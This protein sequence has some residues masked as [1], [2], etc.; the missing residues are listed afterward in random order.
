MARQAR[1]T[2]YIDANASGMRRGVEDAERSLKRLHSAGS[3]AMKGLGIAAAATGAVALTGLAA[4]VHTGTQELLEQEKASAQTAAAIKSTGGAANVTKKQIE[5]MASALQTATGAADDQVQ[6]AENLL[7]T[8]TNIRNIGPDKIFNQATRASL[9]LSVAFNKDLAGSAVLVGKALNDPI[10]GVSALT[11]VGVSFTAQQK[12][13]IKTLV[14][15]GKTLEAQKLILAELNR[16]VGGSAKA[17]ANT[18]A[19]QLAKIQRAWED[20]SE[21]L[22]REF[23][24]IITDVAKGVLS[25]MDK[26][27]AVFE[28]VAVAF[29]GLVKFIK[30]I[31]N[32]D[33]KEAW[34]I[35]ADGAGKALKA[36]YTIAKEILLPLAKKLGEKIVEGIEEGIRSG[37]AKLPGGR[38]LNNALGLGTSGGARVPL[39]LQ[40]AG[41]NPGYIPTRGATPGLA[42]GG[43]IPGR[44][45]GRDDVPVRVSRGEVILNPTQQRIV[46]IDRIMA[47]LRATGGVVG[48]GSFASG[49][50]VKPSRSTVLLARDIDRTFRDRD[51]WSSRDF[52]YLSGKRF[53]LNVKRMASITAGLEGYLDRSSRVRDWT[54]GKSRWRDRTMYLVQSFATGGVVGGAWKEAADFARRQVGEPYVWG[55]GHSYGDSRGWD[56]SGFASNVAA[57]VPGYTG[58]IG[59]TMSLYPKSKPARGNEPVVFGFSGMET[60][61]PRKQ[62]MGIRVGGVWY[63]AGSGGVQTGRTSW[64]SGL[65]VPPGLE[66]LSESAAGGDPGPRGAPDQPTP[67]KRLANLL[68]RAG[69]SDVA[70]NVMSGSLIAGVPDLSEGSAP[71]FTP[72]Q[73]R[74]VS[75]A[76]RGARADARRAGKSPEQIAKAGDDAERAAEIKLLNKQLAL[77]REDL[78]I[79]RTLKGNTL[80]DFRRLGRKKVGAGGR[81]AKRKLM[82][83]YRAKLRRITAEMSE[84]REEIEQLKDRLAE[85]GEAIAEEQYEADYERSQEGAQASTSADT[86]TTDISADQ[87]A[88][89]DQ[90]TARAT[91]A[92]RDAAT[93][94]AFIRTL[95]GSGSIDPGTGSVNVTIQTLTPGDPAIQAEVARWIVGAFGGQ[96]SVPASSFS[97]A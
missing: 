12:E 27:K 75:A 3:K 61:D 91:T 95:F 35:A 69:F 92:E 44:F 33:W 42:T 32:G 77:A 28:G 68:G 48:G 43:M 18:T 78:S 47:T 25:N 67:R 7:L 56:C 74:S 41:Q 58:G 23:L 86:T 24:P 20:V 59:T 30:A 15:S 5:E 87:Q 94:S 17:Q 73:D 84:V 9:D 38:F 36:I 11:R 45:D 22:V 40:L 31:A 10:K 26:V 19:G 21:S 76:G 62:H 70:A 1:A 55:A 93:G 6:A 8:F 29:K 64:P 89:L 63:D 37:L 96:G 57:R 34:R 83:Q 50:V 49:G 71:S 14:D 52:T 79:L 82:A 66:G 51:G 65:R 81:A 88:Q 97:L 60:N 80:A 39:Q 53:A 90:A 13:Q 54:W 16:E 2:V 46:G 72:S 85:I 4:A